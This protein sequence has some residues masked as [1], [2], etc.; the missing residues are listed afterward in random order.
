[1]K[2]N[3]QSLFFLSV[4]VPW[5]FPQKTV[6][7]SEKIIYCLFPIALNLLLVSCEKIP[8]IPQGKTIKVERV[9]NGQ[10]IEIKG[11]DN[12]TPILEQVQLIGVESPDLKQQP[13][14][15]AAQQK[16]EELISGKEVLL[17]TDTQDQDQFDPK[18]AYLWQGKILLNEQLVKEGYAL[19]T[20]R[21]PNTKYQQR[22]AN[23]Q[24]WAR[25]MGRG[26]WNPD[27]PLR[28]SPSEFR[29]QNR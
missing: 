21:S 11:F 16:L 14:G 24:E 1:M 12:Q 2:N 3:S 18:I 7:K 13:W 29:N 27:N 4:L 5:C 10:T 26:I 28:Q 8:E 19:V 23:A 15:Q 6:I 20:A 9:V 17:E 22:L 25:I